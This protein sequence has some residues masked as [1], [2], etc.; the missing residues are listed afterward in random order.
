MCV[1]TS[2]Q[3]WD[4]IVIP[5][6]KN[7]FRDALVEKKSILVSLQL[8]SGTSILKYLETHWGV[9]K[10]DI[11]GGRNSPALAPYLGVC[12][13]MHIAFKATIGPYPNSVESWKKGVFPSGGVPDMLFAGQQG[14]SGGLLCFVNSHRQ[15]RSGGGGCSCTIVGCAQRR[16]P[17]KICRC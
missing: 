10:A 17:R 2:S 8:C 5:P 11:F 4:E 1:E 7:T 3:P 12:L 13:D 15:A 9:L 14:P 6:L 16:R